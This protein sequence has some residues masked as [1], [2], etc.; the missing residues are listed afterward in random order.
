MSDILNNNRNLFNLILYK[1]DYWDFHLSDPSI[2]NGKWQEG[3]TQ[4]CLSVFIDT[5]DP[6]C[7]WADTLFSKKDYVWSDATKDG[8]TLENIGLTGVDNGFIQFQKD[9]I[10]NEDFL[11]LYTNSTFVI[12]TEE[13]RLHLNAVNGNNRIYTYGNEMVEEDGLTV[14]KLTGGFFQGFFKTAD[15]SY[16]ILPSNIGNGWVMEVVLKP[17]DLATPLSTLNAFH[18]ENKG[19]FLYIGARAENK[20]FKLYDTESPSVE[21]N[22][23]FEGY[24]AEDKEVNDYQLEVSEEATTE[25]IYVDYGDLSEPQKEMVSHYVPVKGY[26]EDGYVE[27]KVKNAYRYMDD[28]YV[29]SDVKLPTDDEIKTSDG[30]NLGQP[31]IVEIETD[32][33]FIL[34]D[35]TEDGLTTETYQEGDKVVLDSVKHPQMENYFTLFNRTPSGQTV[36][37][38]QNLISS[39]NKK[40]NIYNDLYRNALAFQI[41]DNG[42]VGYKYMVRNCEGGEP[43]K[44]LSQFTNAGVVTKDNWHTVSVRIT[45]IQNPR[46]LANSPSCTTTSPTSRQTMK[47]EIYID[48][49][50]RLI[51]E[52]LPLLAL[53]RLNDL[54]VRQEG[55]PFNISLGGGTQG[56]CDV[57]YADYMKTPTQVLPLEKEFGGSFIGYLKTFRFYTC[58]LDFS[59]I[60]ANYEYD[61][62]LTVD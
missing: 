24:M 16:S 59:Q 34:F 56:L 9:R 61:I 23:Y 45:P 20:W 17:S 60:R 27:D 41:K 5:T 35:R 54:S 40:Y 11:K 50:L 39:L 38:I 36:K 57:I 55:V 18:S 62:N 47:I 26:V 37:T 42:S 32:N 14:A 13:T 46:H 15:N 4:E 12:S 21:S 19:I 28:G 6:E 29:A 43:Y 8:V 52:P 10:T 33:K 53:R 51:S 49:R 1:G 3:L 31:N 58:P 25:E 2:G 30:C 48:G 22:S 44:I 7:S